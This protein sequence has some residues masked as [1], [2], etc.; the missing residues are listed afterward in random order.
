MSNENIIKR[1][2]DISTGEVTIHSGLCITINSS[3]DRELYEYC[4]VKMTE[5]SEYS[6]NSNFPIKSYTQGKTPCEAYCRHVIMN[7][8]SGYGMARR[9]L[10]AYLVECL[11][12]LNN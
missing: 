12:Q 11:K 9:R 2:T 8:A 4:M 6:G 10:A 5:W 1:L 3:I 7:D